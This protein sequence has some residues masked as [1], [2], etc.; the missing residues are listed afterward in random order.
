MTDQSP[1]RWLQIGLGK[2][3]QRQEQG[4]EVLKIYVS[5]YYNSAA[6]IPLPTFWKPLY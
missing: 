4:D 6:A 1:T 3:L 2:Y 5:W